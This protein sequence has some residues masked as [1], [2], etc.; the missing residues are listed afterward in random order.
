MYSKD[1][2]LLK[3]QTIK[4]RYKDDGF[5]IIGIFGS[6]ARDEAKESSDIDIL[7]K[8][9]NID[10]YLK[11][12][13]GWD[14]INHIV[15]TKEKLEKELNNKVDFVD[16]QTLNNVGKKYILKDLIYV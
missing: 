14:S 9:D 16:I 4:D 6:V 12:Y 15:E 5:S 1:E 13:S 11:K 7:Y 8:I 3:L 10:E 2:V